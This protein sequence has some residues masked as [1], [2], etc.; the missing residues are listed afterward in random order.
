MGPRARSCPSR[1]SA[2]AKLNR[3]SH[4]IS[5][6]PPGYTATALNA[7]MCNGGNLERGING[8]CPRLHRKDALAHVDRFPA[9]L[10]ELRDEIVQ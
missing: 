10:S 1:G 2:S 8:T 9:C 6:V 5:I 4:K 3:F 7:E